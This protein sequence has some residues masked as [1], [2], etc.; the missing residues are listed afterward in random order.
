MYAGRGR[1]PARYLAR[2]LAHA[3]DLALALARDLARV[4]AIVLALSLAFAL[5]LALAP[6]FWVT[7]IF[8]VRVHHFHH[9]FMMYVGRNAGHSLQDRQDLIELIADPH[10][11]LVL[12]RT[13]YSGYVVTLYDIFLTITMDVFGFVGEFRYC[14]FFLL[15]FV[16]LYN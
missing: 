8:S 3:C 4:F 14:F 2:D 1:G 7:S 11:V 13:I 12:S 10:V 5:A 15:S 6:P 9:L 16:T